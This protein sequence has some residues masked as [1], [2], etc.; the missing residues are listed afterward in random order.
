VTAPDTGVRDAYAGRAAEY[1]D[2]FGS[3]GAAHPE[4]RELIG[5]WAQALSGPVIDAGCGPGHWSAF[6]ASAGAVVE[7]VDLVPAFIEHARAQFPE[8]PFRVGSLRNLEVPDGW[9]AG[10]LSWYSLIHLE[11]AAVAQ[12]LHEF[13]RALAPGGGLLLGFFESGKLRKF[14]H[15]VV[16]AYSWPVE[17]LAELLSDAGF[18]VVERHTRTDAGHRPHAAIMARKG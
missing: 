7:G 10:I 9:L 1:V 8:V 6:M 15:A 16:D 18:A 11:P 4:D 3:V 14:P 2:L 12:A 13:A 5:G 17:E